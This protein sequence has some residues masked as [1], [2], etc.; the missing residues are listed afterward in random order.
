MQQL[1]LFLV[2]QSIECMLKLLPAVCGTRPFP[3]CMH[4]WKPAITT[5]FSS[6]CCKAVYRVDWT[7]PHWSLILMRA[8]LPGPGR[9]G[10]ARAQVGFGFALSGWLK[11]FCLPPPPLVLFRF[12]RPPL[13]FS[14]A[15]SGF[16]RSGPGVLV[17][18]F[19]SFP[20]LRSPLMSRVNNFHLIFT[21]I[22]LPFPFH[23]HLH[24]MVQTLVLTLLR[25]GVCAPDAAFPP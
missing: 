14:L 16:A 20:L 7:N 1:A 2:S 19:F 12:R 4:S 5:S 3:C 6:D 10:S 15:L 8:P 13:F 17:C 24:F 9:F 11:R 22:S 18:V 25:E 23:S 21:F